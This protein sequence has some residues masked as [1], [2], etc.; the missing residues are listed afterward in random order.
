MSVV[1]NA[2]AVEAALEKMKTM[3][4]A[5]G[6]ELDVSVADGGVTLDV[7]A[8]PEAC[9]ECLVPKSLFASMATDMLAKGGVT[10]DAA[11]VQVTYPA[12]H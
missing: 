4:G 1:V 7:R 12:E 11:N 8:T 10:I 3:L 6:Y 2:A 5:D 9:A